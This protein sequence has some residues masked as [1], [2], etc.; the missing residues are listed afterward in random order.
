MIRDL[1]GQKYNRI[2]IISFSHRNKHTKAV[3][4][5]VCDCGKKLQTIGTTVKSGHVKSCGCWRIEQTTRRSTKHG[6]AKRGKL[7]PTYRSW[8]N[9]KSRCQNPNVEKYQLYGALGIEVC[10]E[11]D[12]FSNFLADMGEAPKGFEL[13]RIN[14][15][16]NYCK[17]NCRWASESVQ[18]FN[19]KRQKINKTGRT[20]V[21]VEQ[22]G[23]WK[24]VISCQNI[25]HRIGLFDTFEEACQARSE[26]ELKYY[27]FTKE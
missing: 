3:Y 5:C 18:A 23:K 20:G 27:G 10:P 1:S 4:N 7:T 2:T 9:M 17:E 19:K 16:G 24:V 21:S 11:W 15:R 14:P 8:Y 26:A 12:E 6:N 25:V 13:D 22:S